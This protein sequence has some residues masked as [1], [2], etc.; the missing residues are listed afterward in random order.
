MPDNYQALTNARIHVSLDQPGSRILCSVL[1]KGT[2][3]LEL[4][5]D[6]MKALFASQSLPSSSSNSSISDS[7]DIEKSS[8]ADNDDES[9]QNQSSSKLP[10]EM[11]KGFQSL[12]LLPSD[13]P[14][15]VVVE[16]SFTIH[17]DDCNRIEKFLLQA[18]QVSTNN[19][20][21]FK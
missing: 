19:V 16:G 2:V 12:Q 7:I 21:H 17:L 5:P 8:T 20:S 18:C 6:Q 11:L 10:L 4:H 1:F 13:D 15:E 3:L 9:I 14:R